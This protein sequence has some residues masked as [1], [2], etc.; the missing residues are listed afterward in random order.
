LLKRASWFLVSG[1]FFRSGFLPFYGIKV[2]FLE[3][4]GA[5]IGKGVVI[6][7]G[8]QIKYPWLLKLG[9]HC[10]IGENVW[11]DNLA[12]VEIGNHVCIS[13][14]ALLLTGNHDYS[15]PAF[16]LMVKPIVLEDGVWIG[17]KAV[18]CP[19]VTCHSH[20]VLSVGS[21]ATQS[22]EAYYVYQGNPCIKIKP[23]E[24]L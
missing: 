1:I 11:I 13:Q 19:G 18:V 5:Q 10:W 3:I 20:A 8:V 22:L 9:N 7:P 2:S 4:F 12:M 17:A 15:K 14:G 21:V 24:I 16:D 6:K 23:R